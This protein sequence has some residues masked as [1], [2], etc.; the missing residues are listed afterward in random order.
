MTKS[1]VTRY[2]PIL[3]KYNNF[4]AS[5]YSMGRPA[6][7]LEQKRARNAA[8]QRRW[9]ERKKAARQ[10]KAVTAVGPVTL[11]P[12]IVGKEPMPSLHS[13][14]QN[15]ETLLKKQGEIVTLIQEISEPDGETLGPISMTPQSAR[16]DVD[17]QQEIQM[18]ICV[19]QPSSQY[20]DSE[21]P[22]TVFWE[23]VNKQPSIIIEQGQEQDSQS[24]VPKSASTPLS[25]EDKACDEQ[26][27]GFPLFLKKAFSSVGAFWFSKKYGTA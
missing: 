11:Q 27:S 13:D 10:D 16:T 3:P 19:D 4:D 26:A 1:Q 25:S 22:N 8:R 12:K 18:E 7:P 24:E 5:S 6:L 17:I 15:Q 23:A 20:V 21:A 9:R 14:H 2:R